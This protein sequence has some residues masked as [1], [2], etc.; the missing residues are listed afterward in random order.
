[1][2]KT[3]LKLIALVAISCLS[4]IWIYYNVGET[5]STSETEQTSET[6]VNIEN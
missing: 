1:M 5:N 3:I 2:K 4:S 6:Q